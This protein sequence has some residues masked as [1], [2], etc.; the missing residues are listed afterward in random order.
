MP[1]RTWATPRSSAILAARGEAPPFTSIWNFCERVDARA[2]NKRAIECLVEGGALDS[3][4]AS[5][6]GDARRPGP[7]PGGRSEDPEDALSGQSSIFDIGLAEGGPQGGGRSGPASPFDSGRGSSTS[8]NA[9]TGEGDARALRVGAPAARA[10]GS[11]CGAR[12]TRT[13]GRAR[14]PPRRRGRHRRRHRLGRQAHDDE[15]AASRWC[16][17][18]STTRPARPRSSS[19]TRPTRPLASCASPT[20][21]LVVKGRVD[22]KQQGETKLIAHGGDARSRP[23]RSGARCACALD[24]REAPAGVIQRARRGSSRTTRASRRSYVAL[25]TSRGARRRSRSA[26]TT[27]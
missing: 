9:A 10:C 23:C 12:P 27:G 18:R 22:H 26:R 25:E 2:V 17:S 16:S 11:S 5:R 20:A 24:A 13:L 8:A 4:G 15:A 14:A 7:G 3:T 6:R 1:S 19:S 21:I